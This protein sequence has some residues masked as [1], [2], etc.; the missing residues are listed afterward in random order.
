MVQKVSIEMGQEANTC[1]QQVG[2]G[3]RMQEYE[4]LGHW[5]SPDMMDD[6]FAFL[7]EKLHI[8]EP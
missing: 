2:A 1:L 3:I 4:G 6:I 8:Q 7:R 5:Y